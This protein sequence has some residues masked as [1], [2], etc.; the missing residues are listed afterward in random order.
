MKRAS[1]RDAVDFIAQNDAAGDGDGE[2]AIAGYLSSR[3]VAEI[4]GVDPAAVARDVAIVRRRHDLDVADI[5]YQCTCSWIGGD[6]DIRPGKAPSCPA[7]W[8][9]DHRRVV[10]TPAKDL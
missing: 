9:H 10:V 3:L 5:T 6:P 4:F 8:H 7:C 1:Y 2:D